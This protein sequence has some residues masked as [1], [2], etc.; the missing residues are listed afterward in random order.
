MQKIKNKIIAFKKDGTLVVFN[1][2]KDYLKNINSIIDNIG[3]LF[4]NE[5]QCIELLEKYNKSIGVKEICQV[6]NF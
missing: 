2:K 1:S 4:A 6:M 3:W 5:K